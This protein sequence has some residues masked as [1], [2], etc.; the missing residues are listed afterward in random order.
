M[1]LQ[2]T[3]IARTLICSTCTRLVTAARRSCADRRGRD[4]L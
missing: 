4:A 2:A 3:A 1:R